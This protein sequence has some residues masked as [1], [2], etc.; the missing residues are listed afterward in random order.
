M[1]P[2]NLQ[3][4]VCEFTS[5]QALFAGYIFAR[6]FPFRASPWERSRGIAQS[7]KL[8]LKGAGLLFA[9]T[10][11]CAFYV[12]ERHLVNTGGTSLHGPVCV[13]LNSET[14]P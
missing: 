11:A 5:S 13:V 7:R 4:K 8:I 1:R 6:F 2:F 14:Q 10:G 9:H 3:S 12:V